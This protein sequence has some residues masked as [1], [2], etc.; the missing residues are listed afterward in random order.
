MRK[1]ILALAFASISF[2]ASAETFEERVAPC[3]A[4]LGEKAQARTDNPPSL[5][6]QQ[7]ACALFQLT[8]IRET[9]RDSEPMIE[10]ARA[11]T[12]AVLRLFSDFIAK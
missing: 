9:L 2:A 10:M 5:G 3:L 8:K 12:D 11:V 4:C 7:A 6:A 1:T